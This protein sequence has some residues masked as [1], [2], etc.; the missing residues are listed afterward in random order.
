MDTSV[1]GTSVPKVWFSFQTY[2]RYHWFCVCMQ[3]YFWHTPQDIGHCVLKN[4]LP[5]VNRTGHGWNDMFYNMNTYI[6]K[7]WYMLYYDF[8]YIHI[9]KTSSISYAVPDRLPS[10]YHLKIKFPFARRKLQPKGVGRLWSAYVLW[11][12]RMLL[13]QRNHESHE[14]PKMLRNQ[15]TESWRWESLWLFPLPICKV[16]MQNMQKP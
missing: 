9:R 4:I 7:D 16:G 12:Q 15:K 5:K 11:N 10:L 8:F 1:V 3:V 14:R 13:A 2:M 6:N